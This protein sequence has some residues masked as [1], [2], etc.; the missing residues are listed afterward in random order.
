[1]RKPQ[2]WVLVGG[3]GSGKSTFYERALK[4]TGM[5]FVN[6]DNIARKQS[7]DDPEG[8]SYHAARI[9]ETFGEQYI[10]QGVTFCFE[11]VFSHPS[12]VDFVAQAKSKG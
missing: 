12:K 6:A 11:T 2:L 8:Y 3:N 1:M 9:A 5:P 7:P 4:Q 10:D